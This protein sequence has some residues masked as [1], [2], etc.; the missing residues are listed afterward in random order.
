VET[1][2]FEKGAADHKWY[3]AGVWQVKGGALLLVK[4]GKS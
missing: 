1:T 4:Y 3:P 2:Q